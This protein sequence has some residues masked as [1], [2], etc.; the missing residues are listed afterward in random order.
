MYAS[1]PKWPVH[2]FTVIRYLHTASCL[3]VLKGQVSNQSLW[4][5][6]A[7]KYIYIRFGGVHFSLKP[8]PL[9]IVSAKHLYL[10]TMMLLL[11]FVAISCGSPTYYPDVDVSCGPPVRVVEAAGEDSGR[12]QTRTI[13]YVVVAIGTSHYPFLAFEFSFLSYILE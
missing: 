3:N 12:M 11:L 6:G 4:Q 8:H 7:H 1:L 10:D 13:I 9:G 2:P 5:C